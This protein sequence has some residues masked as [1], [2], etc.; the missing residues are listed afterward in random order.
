[1]LNHWQR[2]A[3][4]LL[5]QLKLGEKSIPEAG[6]RICS[7]FQLLGAVKILRKAAVSGPSLEVW[8][9]IFGSPLVDEYEAPAC[10][11][12]AGGEVRDFR[13]PCKDC[14]KTCH[15]QVTSCG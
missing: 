5:G 14:C 7:Q 12:G 1:M 2:P 4:N 3:E 6:A 8:L 15:C 9:C 13:F 10:W 11:P